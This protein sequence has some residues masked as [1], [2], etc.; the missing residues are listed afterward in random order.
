MDTMTGRIKYIFRKEKESLFLA[1]KNG[2]LDVVKLLLDHYKEELPKQTIFHAACQS[3]NLELVLHLIHHS[4]QL[5]LDLNHQE[6]I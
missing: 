6:T 3:G 1:C 5:A 2:H 4:E